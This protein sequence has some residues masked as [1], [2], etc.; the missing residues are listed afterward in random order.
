MINVVFSVR[1]SVGEYK[2]LATNKCEKCPPGMYQPEA[3]QIECLSCPQGTIIVGG[4]TKNFT[5]CKSRFAVIV[6]KVARK[7][8][9]KTVF[10][11]FLLCVSYS[12]IL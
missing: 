12:N 2:N 10:L 8:F 9:M 5:S 1:C 4:D 7:V 3:G 6:V 11:L